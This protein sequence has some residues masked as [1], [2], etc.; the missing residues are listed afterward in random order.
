MKGRKFQVLLSLI[1]FAILAG[2]KAPALTA[3]P[4]L[5]P[6][7]DLTE[8][9]TNSSY[10]ISIR[11]PEDWTMTEETPELGAAKTIVIFEAS[12]SGTTPGKLGESL[13]IV[14]QDLPEGTTLDELNQAGINSLKRLPDFNLL[15]STSA[16][17]SGNPAHR[18]VYTAFIAL[19]ASRDESYNLQY[20]TVST[21]KYDRA[22]LLTYT[23]DIEQYPDYLG[24]IQQMIES[25]KI[26]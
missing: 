9:Y 20:L 10:G 16:T 11:Y 6:T 7:A 12:G 22:Y 23:A 3:V 18:F 21:I 8:E 4:T 13:N 2:C 1:L 19:T 24:V 17:L 25:F 14:V 15:E 5:A 26:F